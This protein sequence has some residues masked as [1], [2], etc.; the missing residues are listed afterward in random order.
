LLRT[1]FSTQSPDQATGRIFHWKLSAQWEN[2]GETP[3]RYLRVRINSAIRDVVLN[4]QFAFPDG[5]G[6]SIPTLIGPKATIESDQVD[7]VVADMEAV[8]DGAKHLYLW[9]WAE[10]DDVF[11]GTPRHRTEFC[12]KVSVVGDP[13]NPA[14]NMVSF[15][16]S[17][18]NAHNGADDECRSR[19]KTTSPKHSAR[20]WRAPWG[21]PFGAPP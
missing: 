14:P 6:P 2:S 19:M 10:Y 12:F 18:H 4:D 15:R 5:L 16:W 20:R 11:I 1:S 17:L 7:V 9:G 13:T 8:R 21:R 3:T